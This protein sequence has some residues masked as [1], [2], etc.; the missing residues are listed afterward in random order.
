MCQDHLN[1]ETILLLEIQ[2]IPDDISPVRSLQSSDSDGRMDSDHL[3]KHPEV[4]Q[5]Q[6]QKHLR[7]QAINIV[8]C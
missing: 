8:E 7:C 5:L 6:L 4:F 3:S 2:K 1:E